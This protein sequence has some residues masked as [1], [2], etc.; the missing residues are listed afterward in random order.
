MAASR[1]MRWPEY[2]KEEKFTKNFSRMIYNLEDAGAD[3]RV[4]LKWI[5]REQN[6][7]I[8]LRIGVRERLALVK[9]S[10]RDGEF[11]D[12]LTNVELL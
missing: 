9:A 11:V 10:I 12:E 6:V 5:F 8:R 2:Q 4:L 7:S 1:R 3:R